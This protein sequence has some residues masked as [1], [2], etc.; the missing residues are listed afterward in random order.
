MSNLLKISYDAPS[1][2]LYLDLSAPIECQESTSIANGV[3]ARLNPATGGVE[4]LEILDFVA[5]FGGDVGLELP[6]EGSSLG[7]CRRTD[8][9]PST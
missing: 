9:V 8:E 1:D 5:R 7:I 6:I 2:T 3:L 4:S